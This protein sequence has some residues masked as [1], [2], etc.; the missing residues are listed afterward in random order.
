MTDFSN[1][2][3]YTSRHEWIVAEGSPARM[4]I[5]SVATDQLGELVYVELPEV[6]AE[7]TAGEQIGEIESTKAVSEL[8]SPATG[9]VVA[10]NQTVIDE[11][12]IVNDSPFDEGWLIEIE[13]AELDDEL[14]DADE[15]AELPTED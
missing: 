1:N 3:L 9:V 15:Y 11:P 8:F 14:L 5:T 6:G 13:V 4:G 12:T 7:V 2:L 10:V